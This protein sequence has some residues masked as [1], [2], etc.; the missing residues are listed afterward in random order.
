MTSAYNNVTVRHDFL[1]LLDVIDGNPNGDP[2]S[3]NLPRTD[4]ETMQGLIT[5]VCIKRKVRNFVDAVMKGD[6]CY[7]IYVQNDG[8]TLNEQ[9]RRAY[10][11]CRIKSTGPKQR[12]EDVRVVRQWMCEN[13]YDIR[14]FGAV[15][16]TRI[17][18]GQVRGPIQM[19]FARSIDPVMPLDVTITRLAVTAGENLDSSAERGSTLKRNEMGKKAILPYALFRAYGFF[20][21]TL[22]AD[23]GFCEADLALFWRSLMEMWDW[24]RSAARGLMACRQLYVFTHAN[25]YGSVSAERLFSSV[26]ICRR[27]GVAVA[28]SISDYQITLA[29]ENIPPQVQVNEL[30]CE[31]S[32][33]GAGA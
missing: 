4:P 16:S 7:K 21:P 13:F 9:H 3:G 10:T 30:R 33:R 8:V 14:T 20:N 22:A 23:T 19:T 28:R 11:A 26:K 6:K 1:L 27:S 29:T 12:L 5:D 2:D 18:C 25:V 17:N 24:D 15:M 32:Q 31:L